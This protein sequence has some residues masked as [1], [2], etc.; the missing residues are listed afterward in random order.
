MNLR[1]VTA[2]VLGLTFLPLASAV[3]CASVSRGHAPIPVTGEEAVIAYDSRTRTQRFIRTATFDARAGLRL[4]CADPLRADAVGVERRAVPAARC[5]RG[6]N[7][8]G[9]EDAHS[10]VGDEIGTL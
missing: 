7:G 8:C 5:H 1:L 2:A 10:L 6:N 4:P 9:D 3:P